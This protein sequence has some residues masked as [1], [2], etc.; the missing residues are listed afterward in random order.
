MKRKICVLSAIILLSSSCNSV[1]DKQPLDII[2]DAIVWDDQVLVD[3]LLSQQY[4]F[5]PVLTQDATTCISGWGMSP[6]SCSGDWNYD[7]IR[8]DKG[9]GHLATNTITDECKSGWLQYTGDG[10]KKNGI[11]ISG[12]FSEYWELPYKT[13]RNLNEIIERL[14]Q[15]K[16]LSPD[17]VKLRVAEARFLRAFN[18]FSMVKRYGAVPLILKVQQMDD[19]EEELY[20]KRTSE[21]ELYDF[22]IFEMDA[23]AEDLVLTKDYGRPTKGAALALKCRAALYA[24]SIAQFGKIQLGGLLGIDVG[25]ANAYYQK[26]YDAA[27]WIITNGGYALYNKDIDKTT[28]FRNLFVVKRN[29]EIILARQYSWSDG[30]GGGNGWTNDFVQSP[31]PQA[32]NLGNANAPYLEM[33]EEFEYID[34]SPGTLDRQKI[35]QGLWTIDDLWGNK[36]PRFYATIWTQDTPWRNGKVDFHKGLIVDGNVIDAD[37]QTHNGVPAWGDQRLG[38]D[39]TTG[40]GVM[41]YLTESQPFVDMWGKDGSDY[42]V[43]RLGEILLNY[44]EAAYEIGKTDEALAAIN[45]IRSRAGIAL[46]TNITRDRIRH[47]R[48]VELAFEGHRYWDVR[49][50][51]TA[52]LELSGHWSGLRYVLDYDTRSYQLIVIEKIDGAN[53]AAQFLE[54]NYYFPITLTRTGANRNLE[55]NP[56]Y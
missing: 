39:F 8:S 52:H 34:G 37:G 17:F 18:Y 56:G 44:A 29:S 55:E 53:S 48:K 23:I 6:I 25:Q 14:P 22:I 50:W 31:K 54:S 49:R 43:F 42:I 35:Q 51:R 40:F 26:A 12:G 3:G 33:A 41:K 15:S 27:N 36:D 19:P 11:S 28:N 45:Q 13:I 38:N 10:Y 30:M 21:K 16:G 5:T 24:G 47:E 2:S 9:G 20:P 46:L 32:W 1:L 7:F 4:E